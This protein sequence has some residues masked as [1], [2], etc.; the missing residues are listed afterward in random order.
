MQGLL[1]YFLKD[2]S[3]LTW[4]VS[5]KDRDKGLLMHDVR[6][7]L[8]RVSNALPQGRACSQSCM[9]TYISIDL[10]QGMHLDLTI[11]MLFR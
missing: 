5:S 11:P 9:W 1:M 3:S 7:I 8:C 6:L 10:L 4:G 2:D